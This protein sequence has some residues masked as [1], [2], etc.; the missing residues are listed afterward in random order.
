MVR[1]IENSSVAFDDYLRS[2]CA[3]LDPQRTDVII[4]V[5]AAEPLFQSTE[6]FL[7]ALL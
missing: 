3:N 2:L 5:E 1:T 7:R 6:R 4:E